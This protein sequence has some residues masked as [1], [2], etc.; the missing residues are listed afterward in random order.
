[1]SSHCVYSTSGHS[2]RETEQIWLS[3]MT[4]HAASEFYSAYYPF[5]PPL[6]GSGVGRARG[7]RSARGGDGG[8]AFLV[9]AAAWPSAIHGGV[10]D[11][12]SR[13]ALRVLVPGRWPLKG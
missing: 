4:T 10:P 6:L 5:A 1:M 2:L 11:R 3:H 8:V 7:V 9:V 12:V 13:T